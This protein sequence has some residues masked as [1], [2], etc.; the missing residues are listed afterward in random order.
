MSHNLSSSE[1]NLF[2]DTVRAKLYSILKVIREEELQLKREV[3]SLQ[4]CQRVRT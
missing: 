1:G 3:M 2:H 4:L